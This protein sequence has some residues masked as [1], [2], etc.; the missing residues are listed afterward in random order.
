MKKRPANLAVLFIAFGFFMLCASYYMDNFTFG[1]SGYILA[2]GW[3]SI[4]TGMLIL[5]AL[6]ILHAI[7]KVADK[8][9]KK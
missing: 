2:L 1:D 7:T 5:T 9:K 3:F 4:T 8:L 6:A